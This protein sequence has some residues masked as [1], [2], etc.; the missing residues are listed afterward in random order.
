MTRRGDRLRG[1][2]RRRGGGEAAR[3]G[4]P[5]LRG[6]L[7]WALGLTLLAWVH[8]AAFLFSNRDWSWPFTIFYE[9][10]S[11]AFFRYARA[12][13]AGRLYDQGIPFHPPGFA[14]L[15]AAV[16]TLVGAGEAGGAVPHVAVRLV[17][18][19]VASASVGLL[20]LLARPYLGHGLALAAAALCLYH[21][22][23]YVLAVAPVS[24]GSY[25]T[26]LLLAL[27]LWSRRLP[28][29]LAAG[30]GAPRA[31]YGSALVVGLLL[32]F[33]ALMRAEAVLLGLLLWAT[34]AWGWLRG[35]RSA[36]PRPRFVP[37]ALVAAGWLLA[38]APWT[39][40]N[41]LRMTEVNDR[42][43][44]RLSEP[45]PVFVPIS[46]Y[47]PLNLA[48]ANREGA[49][50][51][52]SP[53]PL[54][55]EGGDALSVEHPRHLA[56][57]LHGERMAWDW[58]RA[59]PGEAAR[60]VLRKWGLSLGAWRLGW[61][62]W[63]WP[64]GLR[65]VRRPVDVFVPTSGASRLG[66]WV[67][68]PLAVA[69]FAICLAQGGARRRWAGVVL[70]VTLVWL[71]A[72]GL[73]FGYARQGLLLLPFWL[74]LA[75][76][77]VTEGAHGLREPLRRRLGAVA[78]GGAGRARPPST[79]AGWRSARMALAAG[80][81][82]LLLAELFG[83]AGDRNFEATGTPVP[84]QRYLNRDALVVLRPVG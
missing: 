23:L 38:V 6:E 45:L 46:L 42:L 11:E 48:L 60:L 14:W 12:L 63:N 13:L 31:A 77:A 56:F 83:A 64:G 65:G 84:G 20:Y 39:A 47:G 21:F 37:W 81:V 75:A 17:L 34:G 2:A 50:G 27:L 80:A 15:L 44:G 16:Q 3:R 72:V 49:D 35:R 57:I 29:P 25:L 67:G 54:T 8:R 70:L 1:T 76:V 4:S 66:L 73:F 78:P 33:L 18:A 74:S 43:A 82:I 55:G 19:L 52:F 41:A 40:R 68:P 62:Q 22:G 7:G 5:R 59:H 51:T 36:P 32:G 30:E 26:L 58:A 24:E 71:V 28:H 69:G 9:G 79:G 61:T 10:D 53:A